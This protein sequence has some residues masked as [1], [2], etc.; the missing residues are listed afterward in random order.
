MDNIGENNKS[1]ECNYFGD[2]IYEKTNSKIKFLCGYR[3]CDNEKYDW[4]L[5][6][7]E[8]TIISEILKLTKSCFA[9]TNGQP[10]VLGFKRFDEEFNDL[11]EEI[12]YYQCNNNKNKLQKIADFLFGNEQEVIY[13]GLLR[14]SNAPINPKAFGF[15]P[16]WTFVFMNPP[17]CKLDI[18]RDDIL[19]DDQW[20]LSLDNIKALLHIDHV[21]QKIGLSAKEEKENE[22]VFTV[23]SKLFFLSS[24]SIKNTFQA[25]MFWN[26]SNSI[27]CD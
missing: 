13:S 18:E 15:S 11:F 25:S 14:L 3:R 17:D 8:T 22:E 10:K 4:S 2:G 12:N 5:T 21:A 20:L 23:V 6:D 19:L 9:I 24:G 1:T 26:A 7:A 16:F 27:Q